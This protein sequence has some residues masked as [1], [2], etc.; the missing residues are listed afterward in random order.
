M[1]RNSLIFMGS[2]V[3]SLVQLSAYADHCY[4][5]GVGGLCYFTG[6]SKNASEHAY[7]HCETPGTLGVQMRNHNVLISG[8]MP[9]DGHGAGTLT[10]NGAEAKRMLNDYYFEVMHHDGH[11]GLRYV[12]IASAGPIKCSMG[13]G[14]RGS[15]F[16]ELY[17]ASATKS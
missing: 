2:L 3:F 4:V 15:V 17:G 1:K 16:P 6:L 12:V 10:L 5:A 14:G 7:F 13:K 9:V 8:F 11:S